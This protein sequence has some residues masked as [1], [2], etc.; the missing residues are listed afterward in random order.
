MRQQSERLLMD[1]PRVAT[2]R[3]LAEAAL[4]GCSLLGRRRLGR[5]L[6][7][8]LALVGL[9]LGGLGVTSFGCGGPSQQVDPRAVLSASS[10]AMKQIAGFH[11]VYEVHQPAGYK[12][13]TSLEIARISGDVNREGAMQAT[14]DVTLGGSPLSLSFVA[15]GD[16]H[17][18]QDPLSQKWRSVPA[19]SSPV[20]TLSLSAGTIRI[21]DRIT[22]TRF[23]GEETK[24]G[25]KTYHLSG[26]VAAA[27]VEAIAGAVDTENDFPTEIWVGVDDHYVYQVNIHGAATPNE[28]PRIWRSIVL[29]KHNVY[30]DIKPPL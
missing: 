26:K 22:E 20:G 10:Q 18:I 30:V 21:L 12:P 19:A 8:T 28:D 4:T 1:T 7:I 17:Y 27:E 11:F 2:G 14:I 3:S 23:E 25:A 29:S 9:L 15:L 5:R 13:G 6:G 16:T 24:G